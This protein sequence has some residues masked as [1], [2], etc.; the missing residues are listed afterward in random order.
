FGQR[1]LSLESLKSKYAPAPSKFI[2][3]DGMQVHFCDQGNPED[4]LPL[5]LLHGTGSS[6][7]TFEGWTGE[8]IRDRRVIRLDLPGYGLTGPFPDKDYAISNY[9]SFI[10]EFLDALGVNRCILGGNSLGGQIAWEFTVAHPTPV[11]KLILI[12]AAGYPFSSQSVPLAFRM[13]RTP[14][15]KELFTVITPRSVV[16]SSVENVYGDDSKVTQ[17]LVDR[18]FDLSLRPGNRRAFIDRFAAKSDTTSYLKIPKITIPTLILW[19]QQDRLIPVENAYR[20]H[21]DLPNDT[22]VILNQS[23]HVPMEENPEESLSAV[24]EFIRY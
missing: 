1:D 21:R 17:E 24:F 12:D 11:D 2:A 5:V 22:L 4:S 8:L 15:L 10:R 3:V 20:F 16:Q 14:I 18:Y 6:L 23:G 7:H 13:A 19:G 9:V